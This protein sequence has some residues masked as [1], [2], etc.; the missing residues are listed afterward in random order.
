[1]TIY[2]IIEKLYDPLENYE[3]ITTKIKGYV[4]TQEEADIIADDGG[5]IETYLGIIDRF[6][7]EKVKKVH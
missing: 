1:M 6:S 2:V 3:P 7:W 4:L 5:R